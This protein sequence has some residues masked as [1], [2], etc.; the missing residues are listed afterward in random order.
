M[1]YKERGFTK[2]V[3]EGKKRGTYM[4]MRGRA[5]Y[6]A[7]GPYVLSHPSS[8]SGYKNDQRSVYRCWALTGYDSPA[9]TN[10]R[11]FAVGLTGRIEDGID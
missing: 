6:V 11:F 3:E 7:D 10:N 5:N 1:R 9:K 2:G 8:A 4:R